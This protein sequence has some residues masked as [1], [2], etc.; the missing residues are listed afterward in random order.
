MQRQCK[1]WGLNRILMAKSCTHWYSWLLISAPIPRQFLR[2]MLHSQTSCVCMCWVVSSSFVAQWTVAWQAPLSMKFSTQE[3]WS[4]LLFPPQRDL[5][6]PG[7]KPAT[8]VS[9]ALAGRFFTTSTTWEAPKNTE[10]GC[11]FLLQG[12]FLT[13]ES[14]PHLLYLLLWQA[15]S[16]PA[17]PLEKPLIP[18][19]FS[20]MTTR[21]VIIEK[22]DNNNCCW[23]CREIINLYIDSGNVKGYNCLRK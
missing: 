3:Y 16:L 14:N 18:T 15:G 11:Y 17:E 2:I 9:P 10:V 21:M 19:V 12:I 1:N 23:G 5:P 7:I 13:Q 8:P 22:T 6:N 4:G 20:I